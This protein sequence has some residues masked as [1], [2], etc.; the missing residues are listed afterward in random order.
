M[1]CPLVTAAYSVFYPIHSTQP[2]SANWYLN[3]GSGG[4]RGWSTIHTSAVLWVKCGTEE[5]KMRNGKWGTIAIGPQVR[6][7]DCSYYAVYHTPCLAGAAVNC[8]NVDVDIQSHTYGKFTHFTHSST[9]PFQ[10]TNSVHDCKTAH[11]HKH[12]SAA[13]AAKHGCRHHV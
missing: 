12:A 4:W 10:F 11:F 13:V 6:S 7:H 5:G 8:V 3:V 2:H 9:A 1:K